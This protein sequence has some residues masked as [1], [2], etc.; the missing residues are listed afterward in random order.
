MSEMHGIYDHTQKS[1][2]CERVR[3]LTH[4]SLIFDKPKFLVFDI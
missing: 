1:V 2:E 3:E 4:I